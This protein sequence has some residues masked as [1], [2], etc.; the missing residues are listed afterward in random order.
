MLCIGLGGKAVTCNDF[1]SCLTGLPGYQIGYQLVGDN[2]TAGVGWQPSATALSYING[3]QLSGSNVGLGGA[4]TQPTLI[5]TSA[6]NMLNISAGVLSGIKALTVTGDLRVTGVIDPIELQFSG[7][8]LNGAGYRITTLQDNPLY[9]NTFVDRVD[10]VGVRKADNITP[11][12][13]I[14]TLNNKTIVEGT[15]QIKGGTPALGSV[16][17]SDAL[18]NAVWAVATGGGSPVQNGLTTVA[19]FSELGGTNK[20][21]HDTDIDQDSYHLNVKGNRNFRVGLGS[22]VVL[23]TGNVLADFD[24]S[25]RITI[26]NAERTDGSLQAS[27]LLY[28]Q[29]NDSKTQAYMYAFIRNPSN[30]KQVVEEF[31]TLTAT[32]IGATTVALDSTLPY[33][34]ATNLRVTGMGTGTGVTIPFIL[35]AGQVAP[36]G[37]FV[38]HMNG[39]NTV[40]SISNY[41]IKVLAPDASNCLTFNRSLETMNNGLWTGQFLTNTSPTSTVGSPDFTNIT[42]IQII[43]GSFATSQLDIDSIEFY[44]NNATNQFWEL[45]YF[46]GERTYDYREIHPLCMGLKGENAFAGE[47]RGGYQNTL[48]EARNHSLKSRNFIYQSAFADF[49]IYGNQ[50]GIKLHIHAEQ[51]D[52]INT[53][54][55]YFNKW[56]TSRHQEGILFYNDCIKDV[57]VVKMMNR[58]TVTNSLPSTNYQNSND[59]VY[60]FFDNGSQNTVDTLKVTRGANQL[61]GSAFRVDQGT[62]L[63]NDVTVF[64]AHINYSSINHRVM[65]MKGNGKGGFNMLWTNDPNT[66]Q[67]RGLNQPYGTFHLQGSLSQPSNVYSANF[68]LSD[69]D[70]FAIAN[71]SAGNRTVSLVS[72]AILNGC[73]KWQVKPNSATNTITVSAFPNQ[74]RVRGVIG[75]TYTTLPGYGVEIIGTVAGYYDL[76]DIPPL[77]GTLA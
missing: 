32:P 28:F 51:A 8:P 19:G 61:Y 77:A 25:G 40:P 50:I 3:V 46:G 69:S 34:G 12:F 65:V 29:N 36:I 4:L 74:L 38:I 26:Y 73:I 10:A 24:R 68:T 18:G 11:I 55:N 62:V 13:T 59:S 41:V 54:P 52:T 57:A 49:R 63:Q 39:L 15:I 67:I 66:D 7:N 21:L 43:G 44:K 16:L 30:Y 27:S 72:T 56:S 75:T 17:T 22:G 71:T 2:S 1:M 45:M 48:A 76:I 14:D 42:G 53:N 47:A 37:Q 64:E 9:L 20:L 23:P 33:R 58:A 70:N 5:Q 6:T 35:N 60:Q 31:T